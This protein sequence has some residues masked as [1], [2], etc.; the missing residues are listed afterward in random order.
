MAEPM[1]VWVEVWPVAADQVGVWLLS[2]DDALRSSLPVAADSE[3]HFEVEALLAAAD[4]RND[5][6]LLHSTSWRPDGPRVVLTYVAVVQ[7]GSL[8]R[9]VRDRWTT[10]LPVSLEL[11]DAVGRPPEHRPDAP[12]VPRYVDVLLH[13][14]RHL[15]F[16]LDTD[17]SNRAALDANWARHLGALTPALAGMYDPAATGTHAQ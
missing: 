16:L 10:A 15:R 1:T 6:V 13:A 8:E 5:T 11:A 4:M 7:G 9:L 2:G 14:V 17:A 3:P 12:P